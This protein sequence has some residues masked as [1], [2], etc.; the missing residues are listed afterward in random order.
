MS[1]RLKKI[2]FR[3]NIII[4]SEIALFFDLVMFPPRKTSSF[5]S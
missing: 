4:M 1:L 3:R 2:F 5:S